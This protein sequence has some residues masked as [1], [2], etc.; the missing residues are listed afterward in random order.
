MFVDLPIHKSCDVDKTPVC[1]WPFEGG[2]YR[3][4]DLND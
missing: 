1:V 4:V 2:D 3:N